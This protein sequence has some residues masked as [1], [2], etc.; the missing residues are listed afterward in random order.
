MLTDEEFRLFSSLI[1]EKSGMYFRENRRSFLANQVRRRMAAVNAPTAYRYYRFIT[2]EAKNELLVL[3]DALSVNETAFFRNEAQ[4]GLLR[5]RIL[6]SVKERRQRQ[7]ER[8]VRVWSAGCSTGEEPYSIAMELLD[9]TPDADSWD[10]QVLATDLSRSALAVAQRGVYPGE[11]VR[12]I[13]PTRLIERY[14]SEKGRALR[15]SDPV[16]NLVRFEQQNLKDRSGRAGLDIIFCR[17]VMIYFDEAAQ[18]ELATE[19]CRGLNPGGWLLLGTAET[20]CGWNLQMDFVC[21]G[22]GTAYRK[23]AE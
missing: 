19:F 12:G 5:N 9:A 7:G 6:P 16:R 21:E 2:E 22:E 4:F 11:R 15:I 13:V 8:A 3:L 10:M 20:L 18:K 23:R 1:S 17:N 14:F